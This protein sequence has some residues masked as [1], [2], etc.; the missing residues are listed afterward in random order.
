MT[1]AQT[2]TLRDS[3]GEAPPVVLLLITAAAC[4]GNADNHNTKEN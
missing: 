1:E 2:S 3:I 4:L